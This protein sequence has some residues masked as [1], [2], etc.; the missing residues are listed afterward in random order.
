MATTGAVG[1]SQIDVQGLVSQLVAAE[2]LTADKQIQRETTRVTTQI[3]ALGQLMGSLSTF[4]S[5]L[6]SLKSID[7]FNIRSA[8]SSNE[9]VL[10]ATAGGKAVAGSY[11]IEVTRLAQA[12]QISSN[13]FAGD[14]TAVVG[15]GTLTISLGSG[16]FTVDITDSNSTLAGIRDAIN[17]S[18]NNPG[19][20]ATLIQGAN[21]AKLVL[22]SSKTGAANTI[23]VAHSG[24]DGGLSQIAYSAVAP[25]NYTVVKQAQD[26]AI[27]IAGTSVA[28]ATNTIENAI[29]GVTLTL[30][31][32]TT[33]ESGPATLT[34]AQDTTAATA[35]VKNFVNAYNTLVGQLNKLRSYDPL[36]KTAAPMLGDSL[37]NGI[38]SEIRRSLSSVVPGQA[39]GFQTLASIGVQMTSGGAASLALD[40]TLSIDDAKLQKALTG[41][42]EAVGKLFGSADGIA[43]KLY[44]QVDDRLKTGGAIETRSKNL[45]DQ[46]RVLTKRKDDLD[47]R[48][49]IVQQRYL[50]QFTALDTLLSKLQVTSSYMSQQ[51]ASLPGANSSK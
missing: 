20:R 14:S 6:D 21:G 16:S 45:V 11:D 23:E 28:S 51:I 30:K 8:T 31:K 47:A 7:A 2:R 26:A 12:Q 10:T 5:A 32:P 42:F 15:T 4:R 40:G 13:A 38:E 48:M 41:N 24:G 1:G 19:V 18:K 29:D 34:V 50:A 33:A 49:L 46:Q 25:G 39:P 22:S 27:S 35:R 36:T 17:G 44:K 43:A 3:S 9:A 37:L